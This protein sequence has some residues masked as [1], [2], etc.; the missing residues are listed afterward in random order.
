MIENNGGPCCEVACS[1]GREGV[2]PA[3]YKTGHNQNA[4]PT[5]EMKAPLNTSPYRSNA[6]K[7]RRCK[8]AA[9]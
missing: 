3:S 5:S 2:R 9:E 6:P 1:N 4:T 7:C 8:P